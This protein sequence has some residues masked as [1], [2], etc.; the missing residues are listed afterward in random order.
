MTH[1]D[2]ADLRA[3]VAG[4][5][6]N[7]EA[8]ED[9]E[10]FLRNVCAYHADGKDGVF[11]AA[12]LLDANASC[13]KAVLSNITIESPTMAVVDRKLHL[14]TCI[15]HCSNIKLYGPEGIFNYLP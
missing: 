15:V 7:L 10:Y 1:V 12:L 4:A 6:I 8:G 14:G 5:V 9:V 11:V 2:H 13:R 3:H